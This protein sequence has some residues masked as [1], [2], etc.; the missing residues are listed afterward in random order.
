[1]N[2]LRLFL[3]VLILMLLIAP[4][5]ACAEHPVRF[6]MKLLTI[7]TNEGCDVGDIDRDGKLDVVAGRNWFRNGDWLPRPI[8]VFGDKRGYAESNADFVYDVNEDG[9]PDVIAG[10]FFDSDIHWYENPGDPKLLQGQ[11]WEKHKLVTTE[12]ARNEF[13]MMHDFDGD[14]TPEWISNSWTKDSPLKIW[15]LSQDDKTKAPKLVG[16]SVGNANGHGMGFGDLNGDG[17]EDILVG[18]GWYEAPENEPLRKKWKLHADWD[19]HLSCPILVRDMNGDGQNDVV[20]GNP[21]DFGLYVWF[22]EG[23]KD[24]KWT[25]TEKLIDDSFSQLH[26]IHFADL[27]GDGRDELVTGKRVRAHNGKDPGGGDPP[28]ICYFSINEEN[29][30][31]KHVIHRGQAGIGLQIRSA[32]I[33]GDGD[34]DLVFAGKDGTEVFFNKLNDAE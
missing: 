18:T 13:S 17:R 16:H 28:V 21:H 30:F 2:T 6:E 3:T 27:D 33:D 12:Q 32:D 14:G 20:W 22:G 34:T 24:G 7:D 4:G 25:Y 19:Q 5:D 10:G 29:N 23:M 8:R 11:L 9:K 31:E 1:M 15:Q 26:C